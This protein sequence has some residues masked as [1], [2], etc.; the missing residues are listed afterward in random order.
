[1]RYGLTQF[2]LIFFLCLT[3]TSIAGRA[4][5]LVASF[6][7]LPIFAGILY[8]A[9]GHPL[10]WVN[11]SAL[12]GYTEKAAP[13]GFN[14]WD[15]SLQATVTQTIDEHLPLR[16]WMIRI[17]NQ[18]DYWMLATS[19]M[20]GGTIVVGRNGVLFE[21]SYIAQTFGYASPIPDESIEAVSRKIK[22][23][24]RLLAQ[25]GI[26]LLV[27]ATPGKVSFMPDSV[28]SS[29]SPIPP[30]APRNF[31]RLLKVFTQM[32]VQFIDCRAEMIKSREAS[33]APFFPRG[34]THWT[35]FGTYAALERAIS[36]VLQEIN[37]VD[38][39]RLALDDV[40]IS[41]VAVG[42]DSDLL[43]VLNVLVPDRS[44]GTVELRTHLVGP[45]LPHAV[46]VVGSSFGEQIQSLLLQG[47]VASQVLVFEY[48]KMLRACPTCGF[49][50]VPADWPQFILSETSV[51][52]LEI[53]ES[54]FFGSGGY[55]DEM[56]DRLVPLLENSGN[57]TTMSLK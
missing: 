35:M 5:F 49:Q 38:G 28:P 4:A 53:N 51:V 1:M 6:C 45:P 21:K 15:R 33:R 50:T 37:R 44:Y 18:L 19:R 52:M 57:S 46:V 40:W 47:G 12:F 2:R 16:N 36:Q 13:T 20:Y 22:H 30:G 23:L 3:R 32:N 48:M 24:H 39:A 10:P 17:N 41:S 42:T 7:I 25:H 31:D 34:G 56:V 9:F 26:P 55:I 27:I 54:S 14:W 8:Y 11:S 43:D 29:F